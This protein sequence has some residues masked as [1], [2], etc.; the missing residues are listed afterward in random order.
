MENLEKHIPA[1]ITGLFGFAAWLFEKRKKK[2]EI[3]QV[4]SD[5]IASMQ[6]AYKTF[7][8]DM[9][10]N[11]A[12]LNEKVDHLEKEVKKW[13]GKYKNLKTEVGLIDNGVNKTPKG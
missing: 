2:A 6:E 7:V 12:V 11:Y 13:Q 3:Q 10:K 4:E 8:S 5:A 9:N 1:I